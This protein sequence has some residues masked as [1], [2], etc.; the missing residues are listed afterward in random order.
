VELRGIE[1]EGSSAVDE[2]LIA[3][4]GSRR[5]SKREEGR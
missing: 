1:L 5:A 3:L 2:E 4:P